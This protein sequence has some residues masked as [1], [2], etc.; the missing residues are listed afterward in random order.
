M[1]YFVIRRKSCNFATNLDY[2]KRLRHI[3]AH[4]AWTIVCVYVVLVVLLHIPAVQRIMA[5]TTADALADKLHTKVSIGNVNLGL[6]NRVI[7]DDV[8]VLE[9]RGVEVDDRALRHRQVLP[10]C[11]CN[12]CWSC[13]K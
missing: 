13:T 5:S 4:I 11:C 8:L 12:P 9:G 3:F 10:G 7:L 6:L 2:I 1:K